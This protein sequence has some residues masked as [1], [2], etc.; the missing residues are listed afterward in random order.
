LTENWLPNAGQVWFNAHYIAES[1]HSFPAVTF[2]LT[3][4]AKAGIVP[5]S[6]RLECNVASLFRFTNAETLARARAYWRQWLE[7]HPA[8]TDLNDELDED[9]ESD[10]NDKA[11]NDDEER[12]IA[13]AKPLPVAPL[14]NQELATKN[15]PRL[16]DGVQRWE[17]ALGTPFTWASA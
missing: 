9:Y 4:E 8:A 13:L 14:D 12:I 11:G 7:A 6:V 16:R 5:W 2:L 15:L 1:I 17:E 10:V 3:P